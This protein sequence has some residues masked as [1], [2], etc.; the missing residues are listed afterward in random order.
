MVFNILNKCIGGG[1]QVARASRNSSAS[2]CPECGAL[3]NEVDYKSWGTYKFDP[4]SGSYSEDQSLGK[5][6]I[7]FSCPKCEAKLDPEGLLF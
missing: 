2:K 6:D 3:L 7:E 4:Q 1:V 5:S